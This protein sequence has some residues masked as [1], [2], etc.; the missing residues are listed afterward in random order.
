[1]RDNVATL[2]L[3]F[4]RLDRMVFEANETMKTATLFTSV[5]DLSVYRAIAASASTVKV[6]DATRTYMTTLSIVKP[7]KS[8][9]TIK[10]TIISWIVGQEI[11]DSSLRRK[12]VGSH[13]QRRSNNNSA[14][15][16]NCGKKSTLQ[17]SCDDLYSVLTKDS[18][19]CLSKKKRRTA[20]DHN[21]EY[22]KEV[23]SHIKN[24]QLG[25]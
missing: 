7:N 8:P 23:I 10:N 9:G 13:L 16:F 1:M 18:K 20:S 19:E 14:H 17:M 6:K 12:S 21:L 15:C 4:N 5:L 22:T 25:K 2:E 11:F 24:Q 3:N